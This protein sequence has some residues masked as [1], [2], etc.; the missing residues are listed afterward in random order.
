MNKSVLFLIHT[1]GS[2]ATR[3]WGEHLTSAKSW[4][5]FKKR[6]LTVFVLKWYQS[7]KHH[8]HT[9]CKTRLCFQICPNDLLFPRNRL[10]YSRFSV[11]QTHCWQHGEI[12]H[13]K[14]LVFQYLVFWVLVLHLHLIE[15]EKGRASR[16]GNR[17]RTSL[18]EC[19]V[20]LVLS[21][22]QTARTLW[23]A[24]SKL[25]AHCW[26]AAWVECAQPDHPP[27]AKTP[28]GQCLHLRRSRTQRPR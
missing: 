21:A 14:N 6:F 28:C 9:C 27:W 18:E 24:A 20:G 19:W 17:G 23:P 5:S 7:S 25:P 10:R 1:H 26:A 15:G 3:R 8:I 4:H 11:Y 12:P 16:K 22:E 2:N 13:Q